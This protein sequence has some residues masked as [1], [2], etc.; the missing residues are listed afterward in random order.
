MI[1]WVIFHDQSRSSQLHGAVGC[2]SCSR[3]NRKSSLSLLR[4]RNISNAPASRS[5]LTTAVILAVRARVAWGVQQ[6]HKRD[7]IPRVGLRDRV[8]CQQSAHL[9]IRD[10]FLQLMLQKPD[11]V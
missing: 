2:P 6:L 10:G 4:T 5:R 9:P 1:G 8:A 7:R 3:P 11:L